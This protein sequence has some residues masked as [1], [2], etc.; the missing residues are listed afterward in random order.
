[1]PPRQGPPQDRV[2]GYQEMGVSRP[3][4][5]EIKQLAEMPAARSRQANQWGR[6]HKIGPSHALSLQALCRFGLRIQLPIQ[7]L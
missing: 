4:W 3:K 7:K 2:F 1:F 6:I 5:F